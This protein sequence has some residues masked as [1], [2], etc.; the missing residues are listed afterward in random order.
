MRRFTS[1]EF[2]LL[3]FAALLLINGLMMLFAPR[4]MVVIHPTNGVRGSSVSTYHE[5]VTKNDSRCYGCL[6]IV[7]SGGMIWFVLYKGK[8]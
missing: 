3:V 1:T 7:L 4:E 8:K 6:S 5:F 2:W